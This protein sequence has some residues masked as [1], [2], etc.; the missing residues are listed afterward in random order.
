MHRTAAATAAAAAAAAAAITAATAVATA[1]TAARPVI[2]HLCQKIEK[3]ISLC[4]DLS[5][6]PIS[7]RVSHYQ[8]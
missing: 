4:G 2:H 1:A 6:T 7:E 5:S 8:E 3:D